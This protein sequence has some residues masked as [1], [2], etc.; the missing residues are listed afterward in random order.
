MH[1]EPQTLHSN[2]AKLPGVERFI[3]MAF[4]VRGEA[5]MLQDHTGP[6]GDRTHRGALSLVGTYLLI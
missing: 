3:A 5:S 4:E 2:L 1:K 6:T